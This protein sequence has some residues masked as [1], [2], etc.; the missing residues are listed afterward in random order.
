MRS[1]FCWGRKPRPTSFALE[2]SAPWWLRSL[3]RKGVRKKRLPE[4]WR[5]TGWTPI[6]DSVILRREIATGGKGR[7]F[8]NNQPATVA[9]LRLLGPHLATVH[10]QNESL[11]SFDAST[12]LALL[13][14]YGAIQTQNVSEMFSQWRLIRARIE[15]LERDEHDKLRLLDLWSFQKKEIEE[16]QPAARRGRAVWKLRNGSRERREDLQ[17]RHEC[18]RP[19]LR[20][21]FLDHCN[22][23]RSAQA[24]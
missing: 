16:A 1:A 2:P 22:V 4:S 14:T 19:P 12:R 18:I 8:V 23:T 3:R 9:V 24:S 13:D 7:V 10:A 20:R 21:K 11:M 17:R 6:S 15:E 5:Q